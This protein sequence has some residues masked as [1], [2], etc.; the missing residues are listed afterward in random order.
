ML[1][2]LW[3]LSSILFL[4]FTIFLIK[5][6][7]FN[8]KTHKNSPP[9]PPTFPILGNL[10][11]IGLYPH[12]SL[13]KLSHQYG[14]LMQL[15]FG[16]RPVLIVSSS[17]AA[18]EVMKTHDLIL[19]YRPEFSV[20][21]RL[22]YHGKDITTAP[23]GEY[24]RQLRSICSLHLLSNKRVQ[25]FR[26]VREEEVGL[27]VENIKRQC[28]SQSLP[29]NL[30][31][32]LAFLTNDVICRVA[33]GKKYSRDENG[34]RFK[35]LISELMKLLGGFYIG[36]CIPWLAWI[37]RVN[38]L[39]KEV[40]KVA[41]EFDKFLDGVVEEHENK[42][43]TKGFELNEDR[44]DLV[45][46]LLQIQRDDKMPG[47]SID[48]ES[49][50]AVILVALANLVHKFNWELPDGVKAQDLDMTEC[51]GANIHREVPL[52]AVPTPRF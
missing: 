46:V 47:F 33:L 26:A 10:H 32:M 12:R 22:L 18:R 29:V 24:W 45:D 43:D 28:Y 4:F 8:P 7:F 6:N 13:Q 31:D 20:A 48:R 37:H 1:E 36:D 19:S 44:M 51:I 52:L 27:L 9:S 25:S 34:K 30:S 11:Q 40:D 16:S 39:D 23:Y 42:F 50:K 41:Q 35:E 14:P 21:R 5:W 3:I 38:G 15:H 49:I 17:D 2:N